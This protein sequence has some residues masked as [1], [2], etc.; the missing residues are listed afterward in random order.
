MQQCSIDALP[1]GNDV[2]VAAFSWGAL[3]SRTYTKEVV[4]RHN[5]AY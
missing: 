1:P 4:E 3:L 5:L 2:S